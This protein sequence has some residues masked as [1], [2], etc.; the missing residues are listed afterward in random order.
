MHGCEGE[1]S[2]VASDCLRD[3]VVFRGSEAVARQSRGSRV[4]WACARGTRDGGRS[5]FSNL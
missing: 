1:E 5:I 2:D 3:E 4:V